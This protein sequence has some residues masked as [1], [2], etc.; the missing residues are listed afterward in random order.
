[1]KLQSER[2]WNFNV[3]G[4]L[5]KVLTLENQQI[6]DCIWLLVLARS[7]YPP[8]AISQFFCV[9]GMCENLH[10]HCRHRG[11]HRIWTG[12]EIWNE[13][14]KKYSNRFVRATQTISFMFPDRFITWVW[15]CWHFIFCCIR[16]YLS[17]SRP[18]SLSLY[19]GKKWRKPKKND[20]ID[21][22]L[23]IYNRSGINKWHRNS[24]DAMS[25]SINR[26]YTTTNR[27]H[28]KRT[29]HTQNL[30]F[31]PIILMQN[32]GSCVCVCVCQVD[33]RDSISNRI[34]K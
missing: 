10:K 14:N 29:E 28:Q 9:P 30:L 20:F 32:N 23:E 2:C 33:M 34:T 7:L 3:N 25:L 15:Y 17:L 22:A 11:I 27:Q 18:F 13:S 31:S 21:G 6:T 8:L 5:S 4:M 26:G 1:M 19:Q 16:P 24:L 12:K